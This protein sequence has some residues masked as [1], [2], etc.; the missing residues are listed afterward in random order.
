M[1]TVYADSSGNFDDGYHV[2]SGTVSAARNATTSNSFG[3]NHTAAICGHGNSPLGF[4]LY[5]MMISF[6]FSGES[7]TIASANLKVSSLADVAAGFIHYTSTDSTFVC[8]LTGLGASFDTAD[9]NNMEGWVSSGDYTIGTTQ[10]SS[11]F[12]NAVSTTHTIA[13]NATAI[14]DINAVMGSGSIHMALLHRDDFRY[15]T[16]GLDDLGNPAGGVAFIKIEGN[17]F[18]TMETTSGDAYKPQIDYTAAVAEVA[19]DAVFFGAN[20]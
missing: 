19:G 17:R 8:K 14:S 4:L 7:G 11:A 20:F 6:D 1:P 10:Y 15:N 13:L 2:K 12:T 16:G 9:Y 18:H 5:R 3:T